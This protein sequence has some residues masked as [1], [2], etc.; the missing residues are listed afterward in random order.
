VDGVQAAAIDIDTGATRLVTVGAHDLGRGSLAPIGGAIV[1]TVGCHAAVEWFDAASGASVRKT[2]GALRG[3]SS[4]ASLV[5]VRTSVDD[6]TRSIVEVNGR[7]ERT[8]YVA[9][10]RGSDVV[11]GLE[12]VWMIPWRPRADGLGQRP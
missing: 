1:A 9:K 5:V 3:V 10:Q 8:L 7:S 4:R 6:G 12:C 11:L 2:E